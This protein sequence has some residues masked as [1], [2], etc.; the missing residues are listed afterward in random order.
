MILPGLDREVDEATWKAIE[1][2]PVHP[3]HGMALLLQRFGLAPAE[4][5]EWPD[6]AASPSPPASRRRLIAEA[7]RPAATTGAWRDLAREIDPARAELALRGIERVDC[8]TAQEEAGVIA[9][10]LRQALEQPGKRAALVTPDRVLARRVAGRAAALGYRDRRFRR[11][12]AGR[13]AAGRVPAPGRRRHRR[14][15]RARRS[16]GRC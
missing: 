1:A 3:Q 13:H 7:L 12:A 6:R 2:D 4:V 11:P 5:A 14:A 8:P 9:L 16:A 10:R 15:G